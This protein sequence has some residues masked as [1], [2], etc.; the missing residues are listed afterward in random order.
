[1][2]AFLKTSQVS[3]H[4]P[5]EQLQAAFI[6]ERLDPYATSDEQKGICASLP[7]ERVEPSNEQ[8]P[9]QSLLLDSTE[10]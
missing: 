10:L 5:S 6:N 7:H 3:V 2:P 1:M 4:F 9:G 8:R